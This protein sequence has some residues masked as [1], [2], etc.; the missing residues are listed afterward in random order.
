M[1]DD[2]GDNIISKYDW[3]VSNKVTMIYEIK[4]NDPLS[5]KVTSYFD[6][7]FQRGDDDIYKI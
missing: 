4:P 3:R 5:A 1:V 7:E 6:Y 2:G